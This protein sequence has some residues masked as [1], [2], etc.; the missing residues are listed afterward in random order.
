M[1]DKQKTQ[2]CG[3]REHKP[4]SKLG[5]DGTSDSETEP[6]A[7]LEQDE[8]LRLLSGGVTERQQTQQRL[9]DA[10]LQIHRLVSQGRESQAAVAKLLK[11]GSIGTSAEGGDY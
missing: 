9:K 7:E 4:G 3:V 2:V 6:A 5:G 8:A 11:E 1:K 10:E